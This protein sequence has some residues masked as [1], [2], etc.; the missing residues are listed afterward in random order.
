MAL[1]GRE[2]VHAALE[3]RDPPRA[4]RN[5][6]AGVIAARDY[7]RELAKLTED[8][9]DDFGGTDD[10]LKEP[11]V[12]RGELRAIGE[13]TDEWNCTFK[14]IQWG[15]VG[16]VKDPI[17]TDWSDTSRVRFPKELLS[18]DRDLINR[19]VAAQTGFVYGPNWLVSPF[20]R[21]QFLRGTEN[22][23]MDLMDP[24]KAM[25][26]FM[27]RMQELFVGIIKVW[28][29]T[30]IDAI[31]FSDDWGSQ[32]SLLINPELW[33]RYFKPMYKE[34]CDIAH[35]K[36]KKV[37]MH[38]DG[39]ILEVYP[40][41]IE[42]GVDAINSQVYCMGLDKLERFAGKITFWGEVD[43]QRLLCCAKPAEVVDAVK[44]FKSHL[45]KKGG[46]IAQCDFG[47]LAKPD[48]VRAVYQTWNDIFGEEQSTR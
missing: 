28:A 15:V 8:F 36:G 37:F 41:L 42:I 14:N 30:D 2:L 27:K 48:N 45:W 44:G 24:P 43:R 46:C 33:R 9:P 17:V 34:Y 19:D 3:F 6:W 4:P 20:E 1:T 38:S 7:P 22:L 35:A 32:N 40:D 12:Q 31:F 16:E 39:N 13:F 25:L 5:I 18:S 29:S 23:Y 47:L 26:E 21:L 10:H 11:K